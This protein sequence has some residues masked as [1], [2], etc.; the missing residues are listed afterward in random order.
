MDEAYR[1]KEA[2]QM[3]NF[4]AGAWVRNEMTYSHFP[5]KVQNNITTYD[6]LLL[7]ESNI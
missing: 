6:L 3:A 1:S 7:F 5:T 4:T 2:S